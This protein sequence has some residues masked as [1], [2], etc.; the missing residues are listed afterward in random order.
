MITRLCDSAVVCRRSIASV[1]IWTAVWKPNVKSVAARS[2]SIV[3][4]TPTTLMPSSCSLP[5]TPSVSSPPIGISASRRVR[6]H[7]GPHLVDAAVDLVRVGAGRSED[8]PAAVQDPARAVQRQVDGLVL[9]HAGPAVAEAHELVAAEVVALADDGAD[10]RVEPGA[11]A[12]AGKHTNSH[13]RRIMRESPPEPARV[14]TSATSAAGAGG[15]NC[16]RR[17]ASSSPAA[18]PRARASRRA[19]SPR[20][21]R[22]PSA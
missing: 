7:R 16:A 9:E 21:G 13:R 19:G 1:A 3:F 14:P 10:D 4:G 2:L 20:R 12:A 15:T 8:R 18:A 22:R 6:L 17:A 11:V 5:A